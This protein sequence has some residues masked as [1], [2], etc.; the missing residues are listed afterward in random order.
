MEDQESEKDPEFCF[1]PLFI[2]EEDQGGH[3]SQE[4]GTRAPCLPFLGVPQT[5]SSANSM[6][7]ISGPRLDTLLDVTSQPHYQKGDC[8]LR[9]SGEETGDF[10]G[11]H[12]ATHS[13]L[14][15]LEQVQSQLTGSVQVQSQQSGSGQVQSQLTGSG[16]VKPHLREMDDLLKN[17]EDMMGVSFGSHLSTRYTDT[18]LSR[19]AQSQNQSDLEK[20]HTMMACCGENRFAST[21]CYTT[22]DAS[23]NQCQSEVKEIKAIS[24]QGEATGASTQPKIRPLSSADS[25]LSGTMAEYQTEL[26][27]LLSM[28]EKC[29]DEAGMNFDPLQWTYPSLPE[30]YDQPKPTVDRWTTQR[31]MEDGRG[32]E[33]GLTSNSTL[34]MNGAHQQDTMGECGERECNTQS[35]GLETECNVDMK[36]YLGSTIG[37][38]KPPSNHDIWT[39]GHMDGGP[40]TGVFMMEPGEYVLVESQRDPS[41]GIL[42]ESLGSSET[43][44]MGVLEQDTKA[45]ELD[46]RSSMQELAVLGSEL[47]SYIEEVGRLEKRREELTE[48]LQALRKEKMGTEEGGD[49]AQETRLRQTLNIEADGRREAR[50]REWQSL[51]AERSEEEKRLSRVYLERQSLQHETR[52]LRRRLFSVTRECTQNQVV[53]ATQQREEAQLNKERMEFDTLIIQLTE[54]ASQLRSNHQ[55]QITTLLSQIQLRAQTPSQMAIP[56]EEISQSKRNSCGDIQQYLQSG[57]K[58]LEEWYEPM[59]L[60]LLK[61]REATSEALAKARQQAL[62][63]RARLEPLEEEGQRLGLQKACLEERLNMMETQRK[64]DLEQY[65]EK[66]DGLEEMSREHRLELQFQKRTNTEMKEL[67]DSL[68]GE[69]SLYRGMVA[70]SN[71]ND[72]TAVKDKT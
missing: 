1:D 47:E 36:A 69:V 10:L 14:S 8:K 70:E 32:Q 21:H 39:E 19:S 28:L 29:M 66:V 24:D 58:S 68:N 3:E 12:L 26:M 33:L 46:L 25:Q 42:V 15:G 18:H 16:Q 60:A 27:G 31:H 17:C 61:R 20:M 62:E 67:T 63:L 65:K 7:F 59:L 37:Q 41:E 57:L 38:V 64:E 11:S 48:E 55:T 43:D 53:L 54:E 50:I 56:M 49:G 4:E 34:V 2:S 72:L 6:P 44:S 52:R 5:T 45:R 9:S 13:P 22:L 71:K 30:G 23:R 40:Y 35:E 51:R